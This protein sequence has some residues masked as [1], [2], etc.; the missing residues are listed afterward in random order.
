MVHF[1]ITASDVSNI[2]ADVAAFAALAAL[3]YAR[4][5]VQDARLER[6]SRALRNLAT[7][8]EE[9]RA[10]AEAARLGIAPEE[11]WIAS[12]ERLRQ[13]EMFVPLLTGVHLMAWAG[14]KDQAE[15]LVEQ[16]RKD[17]WKALIAAD[18]SERGR[19]FHIRLWW[20]RR[21]ARHRSRKLERDILRRDPT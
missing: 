16:A 12:R 20:I 19:W 2:A 9:T 8:V 14:T 15:A 17:L 6:R 21:I 11:A 18:H 4:A 1:H 13:A 3:V 5:T 7:L 10:D